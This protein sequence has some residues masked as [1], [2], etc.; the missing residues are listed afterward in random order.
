MNQPK[1]K[2]GLFGVGL[3]TY[4]PQFEGLQQRLEGYVQVV[5]QRLERPDVQV[6]NLGLV[7]DTD[8]AF[9]A[10]QAF[11]Q[12]QVDLIFLYAT[13]YAHDRRMAGLLRILHRA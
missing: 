8:K 11:R 4:W 2:V 3:N 12:A 10:S 1:L 13:T 7:D 9:A 5:A 6:V